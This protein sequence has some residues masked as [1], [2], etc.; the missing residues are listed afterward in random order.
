[1][2]PSIVAEYTD[3]QLRSLEI[4]RYIPLYNL[5]LNGVHGL[6]QDDGLPVLHKDLGR[7]VAAHRVE[8]GVHDVGECGDVGLALL[9]IEEQ[10]LSV[11]GAEIAA[12]TLCHR[13]PARQVVVDWLAHLLL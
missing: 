2:S 6:P 3:L 7:M 12:R 10:Q 9:G 1:M 4:L 11:A 13:G 5:Y 8:E